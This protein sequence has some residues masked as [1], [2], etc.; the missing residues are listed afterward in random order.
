MGAQVIGEPQAFGALLRHYRITAG[1]TQEALAEQAGL[2]V[3]GLSDLERG[4]RR[5]PYRDTV[6]RLV[7]TL[8]LHDADRTRL[9]SASRRVNPPHAAQHRDPKPCLPVALTSFVGR[10]Q[11]L[12]NL[13]RVLETSRL[14]TLVGA[15]G[16]GNTRLAREVALGL[17]VADIN[18]VVFVELAALSDPTLVPEAVA[19]AVD[20]PEQP[21]WPLRQ[22]LVDALRDRRLLLVLDNCEHLV[23]ACAELVESLLR[24]CPE[25]RVLA[26]SRQ[27]L[28]V[29]GE[30]VWRVPSLSVPLLPHG[31]SR[32]EV[33]RFEA[34]QLFIDRVRAAVPGFEVSEQNAPAIAQICHRLD[35][36]PL[37][38]ELAA[39]RVPTLG[40]V[41]LCGRLDDR[42]RLLTGGS[43]TVLPRQQ[44]LRGTLDWSYGLLADGERRLFERLSVFAG[45]WT[46][47]A[48]EAICAGE[49]I[50]RVEVLELLS[51]LI[52]Q[53]L[54]VAEEQDGA[55]R[56]RQLET[57]R[58]YALERLE[59]G[60]AAETIR[61]RHAAYFTCL[62]EA[63]E[64]ELVG[65]SQIDALARLEREHD[66]VRAVLAWTTGESLS[67]DVHNVGL[68]LAAAMAMPWHIRGYWREG[69]QWL[70][71]ALARVAEAPGL[72]RAKALNGAGWLAWDQGDY[73]RANTLSQEALALSRRI[74]D[75]RSIAWSAGR[76]SHVRWMQGHYEEAAALATEAVALFRQLKAPWYIG[77]SLHQLGRVTHAQGDARGAAQ[78]FEQSLTHFRHAGDRG[79]GMAFQFANLGDVARERGDHQEATELYE[80]ALARLRELGFKQGLVHTLLS[81]A[82]VSRAE[83]IQTRSLALQREALILCRD[84]GD[85]RGIAVSL[86]AFAGMAH[87]AG[88]F[89]PATRLLAAASALRDSVGC[90]LS[91]AHSRAT[92]RTLAAMRAELGEHPFEAV[93]TAGQAMSTSEAVAYAL[94]EPAAA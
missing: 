92:D 16:V 10:H 50:Q 64:S 40:I 89:K 12:T 56:Y 32:E 1:L 51:Q 63:A 88:R 23:Q 73:E 41:Q 52:D 46:L 29:G 91:P 21:G 37:A 5:L 14:L 26:T 76:L 57:I 80:E 35:G 83:G 53:S 6:H 13:Q 38:L 77:W 3:R 11:E 81:L 47:E 45:G 67:D 27:P 82:D 18:G 15:G 24:T 49:G 62:A 84:L 25:V 20:V 87:S 28:R 17:A 7:R 39:A 4:V 68:R 90:P 48:A 69:Q 65:P 54:V 61:R 44:T 72:V 70:E 43:R 60:G 86:E 55:Q 94:R 42:F 31:V 93:W 30:V 59:V 58:Q 33:G 71:A 19:S 75:S 78:Y 74:G 2:S 66:N 34:T 85:M 9:L 8:G 22:T 79:F 36:I